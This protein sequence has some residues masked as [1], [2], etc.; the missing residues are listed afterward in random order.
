[1]TDSHKA[2]KVL[3]KLF[4]ST[5]RARILTLF[6][7]NIGQSFYQR[8]IMHETALSLQAIQRELS[9]LGELEIVKKRETKISSR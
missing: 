5:S 6:F 1:M 8:E 3:V 7:K 9:N 2:E 4:G